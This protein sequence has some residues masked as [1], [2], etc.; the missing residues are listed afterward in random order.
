MALYSLLEKVQL[1]PLCTKSS[2]L[3]FVLL[4]NLLPAGRP[5]L[6]TI[7]C[8][9]SSPRGLPVSCLRAF[10]YALS[11]VGNSLPWLASG[12]SLPIPWKPSLQLPA[13]LEFLKGRASVI[14]S[15]QQGPCM[16]G[17]T[18]G[19]HPGTKAKTSPHL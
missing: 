15:V 7:H 19:G 12:I 6:L 3:F 16:E 4:S 10:A 1:L 14:L 8:T 5:L 2:M 17:D 18:G 11:F 13:R 9:H